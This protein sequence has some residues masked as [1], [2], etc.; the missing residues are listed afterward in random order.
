MHVQIAGIGAAV[1]SEVIDNATLISRYKLNVTPEWIVANTGIHARHW[2]EEGRTTSDLAAD[3][4]RAALAHAGVR[5]DQVDRLILATVSPDMPTPSTASRVLLKLGARCPAYDLTATC[6]GFLYGLE[7]G[8]MAVRCGDR[9]V[10][11]IAAEARS[12]FINR[13]DHRAAVLFSDGAAAVVLEPGDAPGVLGMSLGAE[14]MELLGAYI[15]AGGAALPTSAATVADGAHWLHVD[16]RR[17]IF[18]HFLR[19]VDASSREALARAG[20]GIDDIDLLVCHQGNARL[21]EAIAAR[22]GVPSSKAVDVIAHHGNVSGASIPLALA[23]LHAA[24]ALRPGQV[25]LLTAAGAGA[26]FGAVVLKWT[27]P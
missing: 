9:R 26:A 5:A 22:L 16:G 7:Q 19:L 21:T 24:G 14:G 6:A 1:P 18:A 17:E 4:A 8:S 11:V 10:L 3:A 27:A 12:R 23:D 13:H 2:L 15:P 25:L 20:L